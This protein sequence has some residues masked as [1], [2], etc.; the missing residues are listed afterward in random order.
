MRADPSAAP[1]FIRCAVGI[2]FFLEGW[3]KFLFPADWGAGRFLRIG[4][5]QPEILAPFVGAV[6]IACGALLLVGLFT[7]LAAI[8]LLVDITVAI[9]AT[10]LPILLTKGFWPMEAEARTDYAM[11]MGLLF[12]MFAGAGRWSVDA[13]AGALRREV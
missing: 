4:I 3:K 12:L 13:R 1:V 6:E 9:L 10:K 8:P 2:I 7:R 5:P 11:L